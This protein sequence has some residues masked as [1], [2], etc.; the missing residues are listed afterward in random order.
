[1]NYKKLTQAIASEVTV[2]GDD[3]GFDVVVIWNYDEFERAYKKVHKIFN[4]EDREWATFYD[5]VEKE[6]NDTV[7][8][9][10]WL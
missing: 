5:E 3:E 1:M 6:M 10:S 8:I 2:F 7:G 9:I 4:R